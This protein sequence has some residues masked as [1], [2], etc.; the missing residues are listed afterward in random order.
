MARSIKDIF[1][2]IIE[3]GIALEINLSSLH[4]PYQEVIPEPHYLHIY[5]DMGGSFFSL[6]SD[7]H[8]D[9][10]TRPI[11]GIDGNL[12]GAV[13]IDENSLIECYLTISICYR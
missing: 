7:A 6:G 9:A 10:H 5:K 3:R 12:L 11:L 4:K 13:V 2:V 8:T 1:Q